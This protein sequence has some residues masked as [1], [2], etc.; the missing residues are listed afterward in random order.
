M[1][2]RAVPIRA[3]EGR[4]DASRIEACYADGFWR[5]E[6]AGDLLAKHAE[7]RPERIAIVDGETRLSWAGL[8]R[9]SRRLALHLA[10]LGI[11]PGDVVALQLPNWFEYVV[12]YHAIQLAGAV[13]RSAAP[14]SASIGSSGFN[15]S[16]CR[17]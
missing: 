4:L 11:A 7:E 14:G 5:D 1:R 10:E 15:L 8:Y 17:A 2:I 12:C 13:A 6:V 3:V 9:L 16:T